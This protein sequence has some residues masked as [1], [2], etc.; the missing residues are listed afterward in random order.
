MRFYPMYL[1]F[2]LLRVLLGMW[3]QAKVSLAYAAGSRLAAASGLT[4]AEAAAG[5]LHAA[6]VPGVRIERADRGAVDGS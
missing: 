1:V 2:V 4:G 3:A 5:V 6:G